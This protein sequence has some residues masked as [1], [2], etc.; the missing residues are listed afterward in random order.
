MFNIR[1]SLFLPHIFY[2]ATKHAVLI[3]QESFKAGQEQG[4][5]HLK[6]LQIWV[7]IV[8]IVLWESVTIAIKRELPLVDF[9]HRLV[10]LLVYT[11][12]S[13]LSWYEGIWHAELWVGSLFLE[14]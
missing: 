1:L 11:T 10:F 3:K 5:I 12:L 6:K 9:K 7:D 2:Q 13:V 8:V 4:L 14:S